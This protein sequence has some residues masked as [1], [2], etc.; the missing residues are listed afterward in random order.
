[1]KKILKIVFTLSMLIVSMPVN[2]KG[3]ELTILGSTSYN[4]I[5]YTLIWNDTLNRKEMLIN[6]DEKIYKIYEENNKFV[7]EYKDG[8][9]ITREVD[10]V[11]LSDYET[12]SSINT[13]AVEPT[14]GPTLYRKTT[15]DSSSV[16]KGYTLVSEVLGWIGVFYGLPVWVGIINNLT[17]ISVAFFP[18]K[19]EVSITYQE[20]VGCPQYKKYTRQT[21]YDTSVSP[22]KLIA[23]SYDEQKVFSGVKNDPSNPP[24]CR[25]YGF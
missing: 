21:V 10:T 18:K 11:I 23:D 15:F 12:E 4:G 14:W 7:T 3:D 2:A 1:M 20:A 22:K 16:S 13:M 6:G 5:T 25:Y 24:A 9:K 17:N 19:I 8:T